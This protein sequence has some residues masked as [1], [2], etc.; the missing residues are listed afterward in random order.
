MFTTSLLGVEGGW[1][2]E[3]ALLRTRVTSQQDDRVPGCGRV[4]CVCQLFT[5]SWAPAARSWCQTVSSRCSGAARSRTHCTMMRLIPRMSSHTQSRGRNM[6]QGK[7]NTERAERSFC[8]SLETDLSHCSD[9]DHICSVP[10]DSEQQ[11]TLSLKGAGGD[12][13]LTQ[14]MNIWEAF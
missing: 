9:T 1:S 10:T 11:S 14:L 12:L 3:V 5:A 2:F 4:Y 8:E 6:I 7:K 13:L